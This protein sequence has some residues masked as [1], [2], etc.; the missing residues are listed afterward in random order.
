MAK[1]YYN[2]II[3]QE[4]NPATEEV[5]N[6]DDVPTIWRAEVEELINDKNLESTEQTG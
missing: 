5:W 6:I 4:I 3:G 2:K 1:L